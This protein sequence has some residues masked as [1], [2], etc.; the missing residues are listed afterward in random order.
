MNDIILKKIYDCIY[1]YN[2]LIMNGIMLV[3]VNIL[4]NIIIW[5]VFRNIFL[6]CIEFGYVNIVNYKVWYELKIYIYF[7]FFYISWLNIYY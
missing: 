3:F 1:I 4:F 7:S 5:I 2:V 6:L